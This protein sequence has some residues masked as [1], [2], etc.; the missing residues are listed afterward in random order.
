M[1]NLDENDFNESDTDSVIDIEEQA[2]LH[3]PRSDEGTIKD[4]GFTALLEQF[5]SNNNYGI[6]ANMILDNLSISGFSIEFIDRVYAILKNYILI[7]KWIMKSITY[8]FTNYKP[9]DDPL[10]NN[11]PFIKGEK[12]IFLQRGIWRGLIFNNEHKLE[13]ILAVPTRHWAFGKSV[14]ELPIPNA[15]ETL[16]SKKF[17]DKYGIEKIS[18]TYAC[19]YWWFIVIHPFTTSYGTEYNTLTDVLAAVHTTNMDISIIKRKDVMTIHR[20]KDIINSYC[21]ILNWYHKVAIGYEFKD[22]LP[23]RPNKHTRNRYKRKLIKYGYKLVVRDRL[24]NRFI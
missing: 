19:F 9:L 17:F 5:L 8:S 10:N 3:V 16:T 18:D 11:I 12:H 4:G 20:L 6:N 2:P 24:F 23:H 13:L 21:E 7:R 22:R 1:D 14:H 15:I